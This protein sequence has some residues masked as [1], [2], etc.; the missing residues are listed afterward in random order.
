M[1]SVGAYVQNSCINSELFRVLME[2]RG[3]R[4]LSRHAAVLCEAA[5][6]HATTRANDTQPKT[7]THLFIL[8]IPD[9]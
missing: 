5:K 9:G 7:Q 4:Q 3:W 1:S 2:F 6:R 8:K